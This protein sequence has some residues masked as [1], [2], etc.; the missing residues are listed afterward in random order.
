MTENN[1]RRHQ[2]ALSDQELA[3]LWQL[4]MTCSI[5]GSVAEIFLS[6]KGQLR[7]AMEQLRQEQE[8]KG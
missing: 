5:P 2:I 3:L 1:H 7:E 8:A 6:L 4:L